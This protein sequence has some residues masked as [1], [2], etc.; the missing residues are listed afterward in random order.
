MGIFLTHQQR[1]KVKVTWILEVRWVRGR[2]CSLGSISP[3]WRG[4]ASHKCTSS[5]CW[6]EAWSCAW[7]SS[8]DSS[9]PRQSSSAPR[10]W[11]TDPSSSCAGGSWGCQ[12]WRCRPPRSGRLSP[13]CLRSGRTSPPHCWRTCAVTGEALYP[14]LPQLKTRKYVKSGMDFFFK[15]VRNF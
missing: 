8:S 6:C 14:E 12:S 3:S 9:P 1:W 2:C 7:G 10:S 15:R 5:A 4:C 11:R 13:P